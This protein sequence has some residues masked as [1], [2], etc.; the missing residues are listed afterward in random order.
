M[1]IHN[2]NQKLEVKNI[3]DMI[4]LQRE[5]ELY[6]ITENERELLHKKTKDYSKIYT[7]ID[8]IPKAFSETKKGIEKSIETYI[9]TLSSVQV[10]ENEKFYKT[11]FSDAIKLVIDCLYK[12]KKE[13]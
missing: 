12:D 9:D 5:D 2:I 8:N 3:L 6:Q 11:G 7:A 13:L 4:F 1:N 10:N